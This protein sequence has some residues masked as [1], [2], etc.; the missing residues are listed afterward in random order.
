M[1]HWFVIESSNKNINVAMK[2]TF[3][4]LLYYGIVY[5]NGAQVIYVYIL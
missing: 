2:H 3:V 5:N 1:I 4:V